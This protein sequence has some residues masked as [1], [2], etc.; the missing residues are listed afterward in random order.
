MDDLYET[1]HGTMDD[2]FAWSLG[3]TSK[4]I[5]NGFHAAGNL[6]REWLVAITHV[7]SEL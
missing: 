5:M 7:F 6:K 2:Q 3:F 1:P 4:Y